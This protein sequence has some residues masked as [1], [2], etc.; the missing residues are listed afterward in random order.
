MERLVELN[1]ITRNL[2]EEIPLWVYAREG[3]LAQARTM[4]SGF[5]FYVIG[6]I[7]F[8]LL[9]RLHEYGERQLM[10]SCSLQF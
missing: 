9:L 7:H 8:K 10:K 6:F 1:P 3:S 2:L 4:A 5:S